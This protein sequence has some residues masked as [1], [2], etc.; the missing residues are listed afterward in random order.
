MQ[1]NQILKAFAPDWQETYTLPQ[2]LTE[3]GGLTFRGT[4]WYIKGNIWMLIL[5]TETVGVY[6]LMAF[7][8]RDPRISY[9]ELA[10]APVK[11]LDKD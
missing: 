9:R 4:G 6:T 5:A 2:I 1:S 8:D 11:L 3:L 7:F 10:N